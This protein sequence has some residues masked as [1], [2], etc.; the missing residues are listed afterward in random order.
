M[1]LEGADLDDENDSVDIEEE[2]MTVEEGL[3]CADF[4]TADWVNG[5]S[6]RMLTSA[7]A[8]SFW[9]RLPKGVS[10]TIVLDCE[11]GMSILPVPQRLDSSRLPAHIDL[12][13]EPTPVLEVLAPG[14]AMTHIEARQALRERSA[15]DGLPVPSDPKRGI[16]GSNGIRPERRWLRG[17]MLW[18]AAGGEDDVSM[19]DTEVQAF[20]LSASGFT[21]HAYEAVMAP[22]GLPA[23]SAP[24]QRRGVLTHCALQAL[25]EMNFQGTYYA[26]WWRAN[27]IMR[28]EGHRDQHFQLAFAEGTDPTC[29]E[30]FEPVGAAEARAYDRRA[31]L[32]VDDCDSK[33]DYVCSA[34]AWEPRGISPDAPLSARDTACG[35]GVFNPHRGQLVAPSCSLM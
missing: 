14:V 3:L 10:L 22:T 4:E 12:S 21:G 26:L 25:E 29:R 19:M 24:S 5:Y 33:S 35:C 23:Q 9:E 7:V 15:H 8:A 28:R 11:H 32:V 20:C 27:H 13:A 16:R 34:T 1:L 6:M 18:E 31:A 17:K 2:S 30:V